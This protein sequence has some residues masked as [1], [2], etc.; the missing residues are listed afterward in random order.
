M[1]HLIGHPANVLFWSEKYSSDVTS[2]T[3]GSF[4]CHESGDGDKENSGKI[5]IGCF[6]RSLFLVAA[7]D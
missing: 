7:N 5:T 6:A 2:G 3:V 1:I 4:S